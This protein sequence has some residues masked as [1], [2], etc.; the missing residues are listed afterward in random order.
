MVFDTFFTNKKKF[1]LYNL[2]LDSIKVDSEL[3]N[4]RTTATNVIIFMCCGCCSYGQ[5]RDGMKKK[6]LRICTEK[7]KRQD[8]LVQTCDAGASNKLKK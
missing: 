1:P 2:S 3:Y 4:F 6:R 7:R 5:D 8:K